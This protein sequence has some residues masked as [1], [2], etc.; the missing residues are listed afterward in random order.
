MDY[1]NWKDPANAKLMENIRTNTNSSKRNTFFLMNP[2]LKH[3]TIYRNDNIPEYKRVEYTRVMLSSH[4]LRI[5]TGRW[6]RTPREDRICTCKEDIQIEEHT[7][8]I[9]S[10]TRDIRDLHQITSKNLPELFALNENTVVTFIYEVMK[11]MDN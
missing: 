4:N 9:C 2:S 7:L 3:P 11:K 1:L 10:L 8:L 6:C 5:E